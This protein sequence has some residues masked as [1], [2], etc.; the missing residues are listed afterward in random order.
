MVYLCSCNLGGEDPDDFDDG[1]GEENGGSFSWVSPDLPEESIFSVGTIENEESRNVSRWIASGG[2]STNEH[3]EPDAFYAAY[4]YIGLIPETTVAEI[5]DIGFQAYNRGE[6]VIEADTLENIDTSKIPG[7]YGNAQ[8]GDPPTWTDG[9]PVFEAYVDDTTAMTREDIKAASFS[10]YDSADHGGDF[11]VFDITQGTNEITLEDLPENLDVVYTGVASEL[12]YYQVDINDFGSLRFYFN[13]APPYYAGDVTVDTGTGWKW[14]YFKHGDGLDADCFT[15]TSND[16]GYDTVWAPINPD[17]PQA[18]HS[19]QPYIGLVDMRA[20]D[21][22][23]ERG[24]SS[25]FTGLYTFLFDFDLNKWGNGFING[26]KR[27]AGP[28]SYSYL[29]VSNEIMNIGYGSGPT[30]FTFPHLNL[31]QVGDIGGFAD[32]LNDGDPATNTALK[33]RNADND[34]VSF[35]SGYD[36]QSGDGEVDNWEIEPRNA[37]IV[38]HEGDFHASPEDLTQ[39]VYLDHR[40]DYA[41]ENLDG[42]SGND[43][44]ITR[45]ELRKTY[46]WYGWDS[47]LYSTVYDDGDIMY[48]DRDNYGIILNPLYFGLGRMHTYAYNPPADNPNGPVYSDSWYDRVISMKI[49]LQLDACIQYGSDALGDT[50]GAGGTAITSDEFERRFLTLVPDWISSPPSSPVPRPYDFNGNDDVIELPLKFMILPQNFSIRHQYVHYCDTHT[51]PVQIY[52]DP[53]EGPFVSDIE[54][55]FSLQNNVNDQKIFYT[56]DGSEPEVTGD[57][58]DIRTLT[59]GSGTHFYENPFTIEQQ[60]EPVTLSIVGYERQ[61][62]DTGVYTAKQRSITREAVF[63]FKHSGTPVSCNITNSTLP[64]N[65]PLFAGLFSTQTVDL[66]SE[67]NP[68]YWGSGNLVGGTAAI[69][70]ED[71]EDGTYYLC[72]LAD[73]DGNEQMSEGDQIFPAQSGT[74]RDSHELTGLLQ[75]NAPHSSPVTAG[76][77]SMY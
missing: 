39:I 12:V 64:E 58:S 72:V 43:L 65:T 25:S 49:E 66:G 73:A 28:G 69:E 41:G 71:V 8:P 67:L 59:A 13:D 35:I 16:P 15:N 55:S 38:Y 23:D 36:D 33:D 52:P 32:Y 6:G 21:N 31:E 57:L 29:M 17:Y 7:Y 11:M 26:D 75:I 37:F 27:P 63:C 61:T 10:M 76:V 60:E 50:Y 44:L 18:E 45:E 42:I 53:S 56:T 34:A 47:G 77:W 3:L 4:R 19:D 62:N 70:I 30:Q 54:V 51:L 48:Y 9:S 74:P 1:G 20:G 68:R 24:Y 40:L 2:D 22:A 46:G 5:A 14:A